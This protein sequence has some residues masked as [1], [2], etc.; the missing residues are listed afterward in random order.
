MF[1]MKKK[2]VRSEKENE[3]LRK[4]NKQLKEMLNRK[5]Q[6]EVFR[7]WLGGLDADNYQGDIARMKAEI[8]QLQKELAAKTQELENYKQFSSQLFEAAKPK[9]KKNS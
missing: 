4:E 9:S 7:G 5:N 2:L 3:R 8:I 6:K 1:G